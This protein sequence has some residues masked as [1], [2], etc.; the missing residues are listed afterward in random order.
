MYFFVSYKISKKTPG[1][2]IKYQIFVVCLRHKT[3]QDMTYAKKELFSTENQRVA[4]IAKALSHP[5][6]IAILQHLSK[7]DY[8]ISGDITREIPLSR[9]TASQH[10]QELKRVGFLKGEVEGTK[11]HYCIDKDNL[12]AIIDE[13]K[14]FMNELKSNQTSCC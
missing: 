5:A 9:T 11:I 1:K 3:I 14:D 8:C 6:R 12:N 13:F 10:L 4:Q 2:N 7:L